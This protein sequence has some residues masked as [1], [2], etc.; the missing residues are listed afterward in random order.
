MT[1]KYP[2]NLKEKNWKFDKN[3]P[4]SYELSEIQYHKKKTSQIYF[5]F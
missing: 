3:P 1:F 5:S 4:S 2:K